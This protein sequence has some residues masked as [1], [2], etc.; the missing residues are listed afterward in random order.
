[1]SLVIPTLPD[2]HSSEVARVGLE[3]IA[4]IADRWQLTRAELAT[5]LGVRSTTTVDNWRKKTPE[6]LSPDTL[7]RISYLLH[8]YRSLQQLVGEDGDERWLRTPN[9]GDPFL[10]TAPLDYMLQGQVRH[11]LDTQRYLK[12]IV[13]GA[14]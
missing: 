13:S 8:I 4:R 11:L 2:V 12:S 10:G 5:L 1:M 14:F 3:T 6:T 9:A 7:E